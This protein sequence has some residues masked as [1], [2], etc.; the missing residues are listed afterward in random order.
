MPERVATKRD[1]DLAF[2]L[3]GSDLFQGKYQNDPDFRLLCDTAYDELVRRLTLNPERCIVC[4]RAPVVKPLAVFCEKCQNI[5]DKEREKFTLDKKKQKRSPALVKR[6]AAHAKLFRD[7]AQE[8]I[9]KSL[10]G[11]DGG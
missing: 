2:T 7:I 11:R 6:D 1:I 9:D 10:R 8:I 3:I 4:D 5:P